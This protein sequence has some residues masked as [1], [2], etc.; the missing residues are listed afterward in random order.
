MSLTEAIKELEIYQHWRKGADIPQ[1][2]PTRIGI[3]LDIVIMHS[4]SL[5]NTN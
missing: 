3:A 2:C 5:I 4:K 1:P